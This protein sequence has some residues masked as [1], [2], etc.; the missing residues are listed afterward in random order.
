[1]IRRDGAVQEKMDVGG[2]ARLRWSADG[3]F[4]VAGTQKGEV[5]RVDGSGK[6]AWRSVIPVR[7][8]APLAAPI[9][10]V[11][12][13]V[14]IYRVGR[15]GPEHAYVGDIWLVK[16]PHG[17][18]LVD[19]AGTSAIP[20]TWQRLKSAGV[21]PREVH[22]VLLSHTHGDHLG[23]AYLWRS[24]GAKIIAPAPAAFPAT[25]MVPAM[26]HYSIWVP[27][28][29]DQPLPLSRP[30]DA[31]RFT[32]DGIDIQAIFAPGHSFDSVVYVMDFAGKRV[33]FTGDIAF[34]GAANILDRCWG[35]LP[36]ARNVMKILREQ[37]LPLKP[38][39]MIGG[40]HADCTA[41]AYWQNI[42]QASEEAVRTAESKRPR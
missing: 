20:A 36:K 30:G 10:P 35:D 31:A 1:L 28:A 5:R 6:V 14:P 7:E 26:N 27:C 3:S 32:L 33:I 16:T 42:L 15:V 4:A 2:P 41:M 40:H 37:V 11:F 12:D 24:L 9:K 17:G 34:H 8:P 25:W 18:F 38:D 23:A 29:I 22:S 21:D 19:T 39:I 13:E